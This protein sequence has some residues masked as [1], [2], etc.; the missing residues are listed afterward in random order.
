MTSIYIDLRKLK[1]LKND[2]RSDKPDR[3]LHSMFWLNC[4]DFLRLVPSDGV[5]NA[6]DHESLPTNEKR[7]GVVFVALSRPRN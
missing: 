5:E 2:F 1:I 3:L 7:A 6:L 4:V